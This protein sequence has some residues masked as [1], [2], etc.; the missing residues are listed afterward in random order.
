MAE[1]NKRLPWGKIVGIGMI[2]IIL[3]YAGFYIF[4]KRLGMERYMTIV[5]FIEEH[6][7]TLGI[8]LYVYLVDLLILPLSPDFIFPVV[9]SMQWFRIVPVIGCASVL[10]GWTSYAMGYLLASVSFI[11]RMCAKAQSRWGSYI[12]RYGVLFVIL[13][14]CLPLPFSTITMAVG[15][16]RLDPR[17]VLPACCC[18]FVRMSVYFF[19][20]RFGLRLI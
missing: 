10:G 16:F 1:R 15:A 14:S 4:L 9:A 17:K 8:F 7:G 12:Q 2:P 18:R 19:L 3:I 20:F 13:S 5:G 6:F 11:D